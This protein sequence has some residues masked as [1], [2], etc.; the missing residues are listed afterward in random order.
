MRVLYSVLSSFSPIDVGGV[1][2][3]STSLAKFNSSTGDFG[4]WLVMSPVMEFVVIVIYVAV[5][6]A[7][8]LQNDYDVGTGGEE[9]AR[10]YPNM[11]HTRSASGILVAQQKAD[12]PIEYTDG[13]AYAPRAEYP[14]KA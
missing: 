10:L 4:I 12:M 8:P 1:T 11:G 14:Y 9:A 5:G 2:S 13:S 7:T 3:G 6:L